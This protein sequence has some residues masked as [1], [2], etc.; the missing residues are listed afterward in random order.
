MVLRLID[1]KQ[2]PRLSACLLFVCTPL[3]IMLVLSLLSGQNMF[4]SKPV[5]NDE[6]GYW[7]ELFSISHCGFGFGSTGGLPGKS[8]PIGPLESH[9]LGPLAAWLW[10]VLLFPVGESAIVIANFLLLT[11]AIAL[12]CLLVRP[13]AKTALLLAVFTLLFPPLVRYINVSMMEIPC[14][15]GGIVYM[16]FLY[17]YQKKPT[18]LRL[19]WV[20]AAG[21]YCALL[22]LSNVVLFIPAIFILA[23]NKF[24]PRLFL[25]LAVYAAG[26]LALNRFV[27]AF[28]SPYPDF[29]STLSYCSSYGEVLSMVLQN[30]LKNLGRLF[31]PT[32]DN[33]LPQA[34]ARY[35]YIFLVALLLMLGFF[36]R[37]GN[38]R[39]RP[40][41]NWDWVGILGIAAGCLFLVIF[42]YDVFDWRDYRTLT[43]IMYFSVSW[44]LLHREKCAA[45]YRRGLAGIILF[46]ML[47][48]PE[49]YIHVSTDNRFFDTDSMVTDC[50]ALFDSQPCTLALYGDSYPLAL[51]MS[52][53]PQA[54][55]SAGLYEGYDLSRG[56]DYIL[57]RPGDPEPP[58]DLFRP[59]GQMENWGLLYE[60]IN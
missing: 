48:A 3:I 9:G 49:A 25:L 36:R 30:A 35:Q 26:V 47:M 21:G 8:A 13:E 19:F 23:G 34:F 45:G 29:M 54:G 46:G 33:S 17:R 40:G 1:K 57:R 55:I 15:A 7:R 11:A 58:A 43:P 20:L 22:R 41:W 42:L 52:V 31:D 44:L 18:L 4:L 28:I 56:I 5:F 24:R 51:A 50:S 27:N 39:L 12:F 37:N 6:I 60:R 38:G 32:S 10:Y 16:A 14:Y 59:V 53:P 2:L